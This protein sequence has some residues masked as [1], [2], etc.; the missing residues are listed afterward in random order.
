[1][2]R[3]RL[4]VVVLLVGVFIPF[5][6]KTLADRSSQQFDGWSF[7]DGT[8]TIT[9]NDGLTNLYHEVMSAED[10]GQKSLLAGEKFVLI[11]GKDVTQLVFRSTNWRFIPES[12]QIEEGN[13]TFQIDHGWVVDQVS[14]T[15]I[16]PEDISTF[17]TRTEVSDLPQDLK[18][19]GPDAFLFNRIAQVSFPDSLIGLEDSAFDDCES[20]ITIILPPNL[21]FIGADAFNYCI[22]LE[23]VDL[24]SSIETIRERAFY[25]CYNLKNIDLENTQIGTLPS[26][27]LAFCIRLS[28]VMLPPSLRQIDSD[29]FL[30]C[31]ALERIIVQSDDLV[32]HDNAFGHCDNLR[33]IIFTKGKPAAIG[34]VLYQDEAEVT[35]PYPTLYYTADYANEWA[36]NGETEWN[37]YPIQQI[38][39]AEL[40]S[41]LAQARGEA[42]LEAAST[43]STS[44]WIAAVAIALLALGGTVWVA[45]KRKKKIHR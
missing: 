40:D 39:Q 34:S 44:W 21:N 32:I 43:D 14:K 3:N 45:R 20:L 17:E 15:L 23:R 19:I 30:N 5:I 22:N 28:E 38:S 33:N 35:I 26:R 18:F 16:C 9:S 2:R 12:V 31:I 27:T 4:L 7:Q 1:M 8:L 42:A 13:A 24:P 10:K 37:G 36:P 41:F 11:I 29:A 25:S 6:G